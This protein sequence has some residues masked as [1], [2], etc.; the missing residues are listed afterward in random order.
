MSLQALRV[1]V[2]DESRRA[3]ARGGHGL[4]LGRRSEDP[5]TRYAHSPPE[6]VAALAAAA[7]RRKR[8]PRVKRK[9]K[10]EERAD[11][12]DVTQQQRAHF[13]V[14][15]FLLY[16]V[17]TVSSTLKGTGRAVLAFGAAAGRDTKKVR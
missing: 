2:H 5:N 10:A 12:A 16:A 14:P 6:V 9:V 4:I 8:N 17:T 13:V 1:L 15:D 7:K 11:M 3:M